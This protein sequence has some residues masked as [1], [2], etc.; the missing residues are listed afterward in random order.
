MQGRYPADPSQQLGR[1]PSHLAAICEVGSCA[2]EICSGIS[3][4]LEGPR[5]ADRVSSRVLSGTKNPNL[6]AAL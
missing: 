5:K 2:G 1:G 3:S 6:D 4:A